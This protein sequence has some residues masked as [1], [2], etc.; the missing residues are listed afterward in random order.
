M[1]KA[2]EEITLSQTAHL[3]HKDYQWVRS[4][5]F[6][7]ELTGRQITGRWL[8][9]LDSALLLQGTVEQDEPR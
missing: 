5:L 4:R 8:V 3:L 2:T 6:R 9:E 1:S 7:G